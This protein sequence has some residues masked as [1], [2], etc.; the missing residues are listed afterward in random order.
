MSQPIQPTNIPKNGYKTAN[1]IYTES[2]K[3]AGTGVDIWLRF[4]KYWTGDEW[5]DSLNR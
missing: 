5:D 4:S 3:A 2:T 1:N